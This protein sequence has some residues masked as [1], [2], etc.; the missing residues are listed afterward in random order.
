MGRSLGLVQTRFRYGKREKESH[1]TLCSMPDDVAT[2]GGGANFL[3]P[4]TVTAV[5]VFVERMIRISRVGRSMQ[6]VV[7]ALVLFVP[8]M[9]ATR[10]SSASHDQ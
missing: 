5:P 7:L 9:A 4:I 3:R 1:N 2:T 10:A 8:T 6:H